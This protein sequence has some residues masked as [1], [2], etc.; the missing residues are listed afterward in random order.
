MSL[1]STKTNSSKVPLLYPPMGFMH[2]ED[3][4]CRCH[5]PVVPQNLVFLKSL[6]LGSIINISGI[7]TPELENFSDENHIDLVS[8]AM[9]DDK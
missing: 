3:R 9:V 4:I 1:K 8:F 7:A 2:I 5:V 6:T